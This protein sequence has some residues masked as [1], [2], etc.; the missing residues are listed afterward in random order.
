M[1]RAARSDVPPS[2]APTRRP[3]SSLS[4]V[5][6]PAPRRT[7]TAWHVSKYGSLNRN[8]RSRSGVAPIVAAT[9]STRPARTAGSNSSYGITST[10]ASK[11]AFRATQRASSTS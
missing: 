6:S 8:A 10:R 3:R 11:P 4:R 2:D 9:R 7:T 1:P 5:G